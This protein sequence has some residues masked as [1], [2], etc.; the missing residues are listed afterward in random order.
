WPVLTMSMSCGSIC[1]SMSSRSL[2]GT[3]SMSASP[4]PT[5]PP[6]VCTLRSTTPA[7]VSRAGT[8]GRSE[9]DG[10]DE[11]WGLFRRGVPCDAA[12]FVPNQAHHKHIK[13][14]EHNEP[15]SMRVREAIELV[16]NEKS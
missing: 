16:N 5:T 13:H 10:H 9:V 15:S 3:M 6:G 8:M 14:G 4:C 1:A 7:S 12:M 11:G 2:S